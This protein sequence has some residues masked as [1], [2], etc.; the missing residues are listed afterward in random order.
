M[1]A[2]SFVPILA[3]C[4]QLL[5]HVSI[6][7]EPATMGQM[8]C[9]HWLP[10]QSGKEAIED[11]GATLEAYVIEKENRN[12]QAKIKLAR[13]YEDEGASLKAL[14]VY[15]SI[16]QNNP[17]SRVAVNV[18]LY[19][20]ARDFATE[21][22]ARSGDQ[23]LE[24]YR[25]IY[26]SVAGKGLSE[27]LKNPDQQKLETV[28]RDYLLSSAGPEAVQRVADL[29][30][31]KGEF[32]SAVGQWQEL[33][34][35]RGDL[36]FPDPIT[37]LKL[38][39]CYRSLGYQQ[40]FQQLLARLKPHLDEKYVIAGKPTKV[41]DFL[42]QLE[43]IGKDRAVDWAD[44]GGD[45][46]HSRLL[47]SPA[48]IGKLL[49]SSS[50]LGPALR[51]ESAG[52]SEAGHTSQAGEGL[53]LPRIFPVI[54]DDNIYYRVAN[55]VIARRVGSGEILWRHS[56]SGQ[57]LRG[58][59][60]WA[61]RPQM[62]AVSEDSVYVC[63]GPE[64]R[65]RFHLSEA[66]LRC[67]RKS[68]GKVLWDALAS[69]GVL[70]E[71][72]R[73]D[74]QDDAA[75]SETFIGAPTVE[76]DRLYVGVVTR[77]RDTEC[78]LA[79]LDAR[80]GKRIWK[81]FISLSVRQRVY[82][83]YAPLPAGGLPA[84]ADGL[85]YYS[86][87]RG[88][89]I[90]A[91]KM[92]GVPKWI[93]RY[94]RKPGNRPAISLG[95]DEGLNSW[96]LNAPLVAGGK[97]FVTP[98]D[99]DFL[100]CFDSIT[101][102]QL[103]EANRGQNTYLLGY[104]DGR[105]FL[106]GNQ[107]SYLDADNGKLVNR[108]VRLDGTPAGLGLVG[109]RLVH[110]P[111]SGRLHRSFVGNGKLGHAR[112]WDRGMGPGNLMHVG[113]LFIV[114][115][116]NG[117]QVYS[118]E[119]YFEQQV[120]R[121]KVSPQDA[122]AHH[123]VGYLMLS[124]DRLDEA[125][126]YL[127]T[128]VEL[129]RKNRIRNGRPVY[130][131]SRDLL[132]QAL[133][134]R[135]DLA[136]EGADWVAAERGYALALQ[137]A[138]SDKHKF[139]AVL[140]LSR[141]AERRGQ[142]KAAIHYLQQ[143]GNHPHQSMIEMDGIAVS[144]TFYPRQRIADIIRKHGREPYKAFEAAA[145]QLLEKAGHQDWAVRCNEIVELYPNSEAA[146]QA[147]VVLGT[148]WLKQGKPFKSF[149]FWNDLF[150]RSGR[151]NLRAGVNLAITCA[152][153]Q[154]T[155]SA[156]RIIAQLKQTH[157]SKLYKF[158]EQ[159]TQ[160]EAL[161]NHL[162]AALAEPQAK[163]KPLSLP[164]KE[165]WYRDA[166]AISSL[167][168]SQSF[169]NVCL[170]VWHSD[171]LTFVGRGGMDCLNSNTGKKVW[172]REM[173]TRTKGWLGISY[174]FG[175]VI[176]AII[177]T[178]ARRAGL[179]PGDIIRKVN[180]ERIVASTVLQAAIQEAPRDRPIQIEVQRE[181]PKPE[182]SSETDRFRTRSEILTVSVRLKS[183]PQNVRLAGVSGDTIV[184]GTKGEL[185]GVDAQTGAQI[186]AQA[187]DEFAMPG[188]FLDMNRR[189][190]PIG[191]NP[192]ETSP[193]SSGPESSHLGLLALNILD[194]KLLMLRAAD[195][196]ILWEMPLA[197]LEGNPILTPEALFVFQ[198]QSE[199]GEAFVTALN[200][201]RGLV[202]YRMDLGVKADPGSGFKLLGDGNFAALSQAGI[203]CRS[204]ATGGLV[205][206]HDFEGKWKTQNLTESKLF[207]SGR[208][209][210]AGAGSLLIAVDRRT[211]KT[212]W[213]VRLRDSHKWLQRSSI[214]KQGFFAISA[215][216]EMKALEL[217]TGREIWSES[218]NRIALDVEYPASLHDGL[219]FIP[220]HATGKP[221]STTLKIRDPRT[222]R[223]SQELTIAGEFRYSRIVGNTYVI[224][225]NAGAFGFKGAGEE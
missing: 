4:C 120:E 109:T 48:E 18:R 108:T 110:C 87:N 167:I 7:G 198:H 115:G 77:T 112:S 133:T 86:T 158:L 206:Q 193:V 171:R 208:V 91:D 13:E 19:W 100:Q 150:R 172:E 82:R 220:Q 6:H 173:R 123:E 207:H 62:L 195:G 103:W 128:A 93:R 213:D 2:A 151:K 179:K 152:L 75:A 223:I 222:G 26:D 67:I 105:V 131:E 53:S 181:I 204:V 27:A 159:D 9:R 15:Q 162:F 58:D 119:G 25:D 64:M 139:N 202:M 209:I 191:V 114:A 101:G 66:V 118:S 160:F 104:R 1:S 211:G 136:A 144:S 36:P 145:A 65:G 44:F 107:I 183:P 20:P 192:P 169:D 37:P 122:L 8:P 49:W 71:N 147:K 21:K 99:S 31:S 180:G 221:S 210:I 35:F 95:P 218:P 196:D 84:L 29:M 79:C 34:R 85:V 166:E 205:W 140:N 43:T 155:D 219:L 126:E 73:E 186:W 156:R 177:D 76:G 51:P 47:N 170:P 90:A 121:A 74:W 52:E 182:D 106:S 56:L 17:N 212:L 38:A 3:L 185:F 60:P 201:F 41:A 194:R 63:F 164:L 68:D 187:F 23:A 199:S 215:S 83:S 14:S 124:R 142:W 33:A 11:D 81:T 57:P 46:R 175:R 161:G 154:E 135:A 50:W 216:G 203:Q 42:N 148:T 113:K 10:D 197:R 111:G 72:V 157:G 12:L 70:G 30:L 89:I 149:P 163:R 132:F 61:T 137:T 40:E 165:Q 168:L 92:T 214:G 54:S 102:R 153:L 55:G 134:R 28:A 98:Q 143:I 45:K 189:L 127:T 5:W 130:E 188:V 200:P 69:E 176:K 94:E 88:A 80:T 22:L 116:T 174:G 96:L 225:T 217:Y 141:Y 59:Q 184:C 224:V 24:A 178:P 138:P 32:A 78:Y 97:I 129:S 39:L 146:V 125:V 190:A 16:L 117:L